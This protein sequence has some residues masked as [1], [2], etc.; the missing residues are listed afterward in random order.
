VDP[1]LVSQSVNTPAG[2]DVIYKLY[3]QHEGG[4]ATEMSRLP[5]TTRGSFAPR[6]LFA[7][8]IPD[9]GV[10]LVSNTAGQRALR[11]LYW[12]PFL[13]IGHHHHFLAMRLD[14]WGVDT[15]HFSPTSVTDI[16]VVTE[17]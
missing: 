14:Q 1:Y 4:V 5:S 15:A 12:H 16:T 2:R 6:G 7:L 11:V 10:N 9:L 8:T 3:G 17:V 13:M